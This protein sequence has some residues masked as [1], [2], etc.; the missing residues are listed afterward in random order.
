MDSNDD[1]S[2]SIQLGLGNINLNEFKETYRTNS[3]QQDEQLSSETMEEIGSKLSEAAGDGDSQTVRE[4]LR[5]VE[6][7]QLLD[8]WYKRIALSQAS[9]NGHVEVVK[10]LLEAKS[11]DKDQKCW[12]IENALCEA[13]RG[14]YTDVAKLLLETNPID[15]NRCIDVRGYYEDEKTALHYASEFGHVEVV[16]L[17]LGTNAV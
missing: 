5:R 8:S 4:L 2:D 16:K 17:L 3:Q 13:S 7:I 1:L 15:V 6:V 14:G 12:E 11:I 9:E 10:L